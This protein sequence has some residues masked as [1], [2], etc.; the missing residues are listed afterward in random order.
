MASA[1]R[2]EQDFC[3]GMETMFGRKIPFDPDVKH[4]IDEGIKE[5]RCMDPEKRTQV[6]ET[7]GYLCYDI[8]I[9]E[10]LQDL[11]DAEIAKGAKQAAENCIKKRLKE[12]KHPLVEEIFHV[13]LPKKEAFYQEAIGYVKLL[14]EA[15]EAAEN[16]REKK[17]DEGK[18]LAT[19]E[20]LEMQPKGNSE[21]KATESITSFKEGRVV[22]MRKESETRKRGPEENEKRENRRCV[23]KRKFP[24]RC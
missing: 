6:I 4:V 9:V 15:K 20:P 3:E 12:M 5:S 11:E 14:E 23:T 24:I 22:E 13:P 21:E 1:A 16:Y 19:E 18:L 7:A 8:M 17:F 10:S 2:Y